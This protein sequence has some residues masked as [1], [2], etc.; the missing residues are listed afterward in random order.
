[1]PAEI[2]G[3]GTVCRLASTPLARPNTTAP[4]KH[5]VARA[6]SANA[7][8][9]LVQGCVI[10]PHTDLLRCAVFHIHDLFDCSVC[11]VQLRSV[12]DCPEE[13]GSEPPGVVQ[14]RQCKLVSR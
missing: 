3:R 8:H 1:M 2:S 9:R 12:V 11:D 4:T 6:G 10:R 7:I 5:D 13:F 14:W